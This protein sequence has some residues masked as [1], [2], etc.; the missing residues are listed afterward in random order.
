MFI[1]GRV[2]LL[3]GHHLVRG[4]LLS[5]AL[6]LAGVSCVMYVAADGL[7]SMCFLLYSFGQSF[8]PDVLSAKL[9]QSFPTLCNPMHCSLA[10]SSVHGILQAR[11]L[12]W[13]TMPFSKGN[14]PTQ[15]SNP[16]LLPLLHRQPDSLPLAPPGK[17]IQF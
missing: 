8:S 12:E 9:L 1:T 13:V 4:T 3:D 14:F 2:I 7:V 10:V 15:G 6:C 11:I 16:C 17:P 5:W